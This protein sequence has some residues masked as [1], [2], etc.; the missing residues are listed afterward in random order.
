[1]YLNFIIFLG[2]HPVYNVGASI[3]FFNVGASYSK[4]EWTQR[5]NS[6]YLRLKSSKYLHHS[7]K[8]YLFKPSKPCSYFSLFIFHHFH[9]SKMIKT[10][11]I[12]LLFL[13][14]IVI[15]R[16]WLKNVWN[17]RNAMHSGAS[18]VSGYYTKPIIKKMGV[19]N[20]QF[21]FRK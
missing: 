13:S 5:R 15:C 17:E 10:G 9:L 16:T 8:R 21:R 7:Y 20:S 6:E 2:G 11:F 18:A 12:W 19:F 14:H 1:M 3:A 4:R